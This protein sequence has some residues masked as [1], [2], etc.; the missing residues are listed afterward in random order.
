VTVQAQIVALRAAR[1]AITT[2][3]AGKG[4]TVPAGSGFADFANLIDS[5]SAGAATVPAALTSGQWTVTDTEEGGAISINITELPD[6]GGS[7]ITALEYRIDGGTAVALTGT[8]TGA[9]TVTGLT[10]DVE[11]DVE[12]RAVNA[13]GASAWS[14]VKAVTPTEA[15]APSLAYI[16]ESYTAGSGTIN[17]TRPAGATSAHTLVAI[18]FTGAYVSGPSGSAAVAGTPAPTG[19]TAVAGLVAGPDP[20]ATDGEG[21]R[22]FT[23]PGDVASLTFVQTNLTDVLIFCVAGTLRAGSSF[24]GVNSGN[25]P[26]ADAPTASITASEGDLI[27]S[28]YIQGNDGA[29]GSIAGSVTAGYTREYLKDDA[30]PRI[31]IA[32]REEV[33]AGATGAVSHG[34]NAAF[35]TRFLFTGAFGA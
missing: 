2:A 14:D 21:A 3:I 12:V 8:G 32:T 28:A 16:S 29:G 23:A 31:S 5:I 15:D 34:G 1:T 6:D 27:V 22:V 9:R 17:A 7:A 30:I 25:N 4:V 19:W 11:A 26:G 24:T 18:A 10:D 13:V 35:A 20:E 33:S